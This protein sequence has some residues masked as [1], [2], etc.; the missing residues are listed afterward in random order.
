MT[1]RNRNRGVLVTHS[2][3]GAEIARWANAPVA[4]LAGRRRVLNVPRDVLDMRD[5]PY[6]PTLEPLP[7][8]VDQR[9][10]IAARLIRDQGDEGSCTG[11]ATAAVVNH[12]RAARR[13]SFDASPR[14]L[15]ENARRYD[16]W[17]G[18]EYEGSSIRGAM[19]GFHKHG[20]CPWKVL[21][22]RP[23]ESFDRLPREALAA[24]QD[25]PLGAYFRVSTSAINDLQS[26]LFEVGAVLVSAQVH[27]G[28]DAPRK[29]AD[30][31]ARIAWRKANEPQ[32]GHAF[33]LVGYTPDGFI[34]QN[35]WGT[36][37]GSIA[38][39]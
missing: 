22:Y 21:P 32:G 7:E 34:V 11:F 4:S 26:A 38:A 24:A 14:F 8:R 28:W 25:G 36:D 12:L 35:S 15:Y 13:E 5:R 18:E 33:A 9:R 29:S 30:G 37:W 6:A 39:P 31:L 1:Y 27:R 17:K 19:K 10:R 3:T 16:E 2:G 20:V 23:G